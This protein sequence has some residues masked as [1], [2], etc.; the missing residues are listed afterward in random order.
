MEQVENG[1]GVFASSLVKVSEL[2]LNDAFKCRSTKVC[3][4]FKSKTILRKTHP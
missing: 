4:S 3:A 1:I 2:K